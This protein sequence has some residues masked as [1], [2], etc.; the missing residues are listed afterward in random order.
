[1]NHD[2]N[3]NDKKKIQYT[4]N[5]CSLFMGIVGVIRPLVKDMKTMMQILKMVCD[6]PNTTSCEKL[7]EISKHYFGRG[8]EYF[9]FD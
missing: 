7:G 9:N 5:N 1:M 2:L 8:I 6:K 4:S 3:K